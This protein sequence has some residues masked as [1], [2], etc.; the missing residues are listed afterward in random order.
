MTIYNTCSAYMEKKSI[1]LPLPYMYFS[2]NVYNRD[3]HNFF[4]LTK[5]IGHI[6]ANV[7]PLHI[8]HTGEGSILVAI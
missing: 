5:V 3:H 6:I 1:I 4:P 8:T 2:I 7:Y